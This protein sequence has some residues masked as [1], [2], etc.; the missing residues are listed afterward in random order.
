MT[1]VIRD[2]DDSILVVV[3]CVMPCA[4]LQLLSFKCC[5][6]APLLTLCIL[7]RRSSRRS[8]HCDARCACPFYEIST[9][10]SATVQYRV[11]CGMPTLAIVDFV[12]GLCLSIATKDR[13]FW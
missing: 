3:V 6:L 10:L 8:S 1:Y 13:L 5:V 12:L 7:L 9:R 4:L 11:Y 2:F